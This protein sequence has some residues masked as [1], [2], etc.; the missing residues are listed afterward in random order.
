VARRRDAV[1]SAADDQDT[2]RVD[3]RRVGERVLNSDQTAHRADIDALAAHQLRE[4]NARGLPFEERVDRADS[5]DDRDAEGQVPV[6]IRQQRRGRAA[7]RHAGDADLSD[8]AVPHVA[9]VDAQIV[10]G[11]KRDFIEVDQSRDRRRPGH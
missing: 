7:E 1:P 8:A 11:V 2:L 5:R 9:D 10:D 4:Q 6:D 3:L